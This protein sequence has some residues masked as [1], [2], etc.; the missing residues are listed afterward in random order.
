MYNM[1][2]TQPKPEP[3]GF[4]EM[5]TDNRSR[6]NAAGNSAA[7]LLI[8]LARRF[9]DASATLPGS[10]S[11]CRGYLDPRTSTAEYGKVFS[12][13]QCEREFVRSALASLTVE[14]C[15][16]MQWR[17]ENLLTAVRE[18]AR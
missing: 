9:A 6:G 7:S 17:L 13:R 4:D 12:S 1:S 11:H 14:D 8:E 5:E 10:C 18:P 2:A 16:R 15:I 3:R